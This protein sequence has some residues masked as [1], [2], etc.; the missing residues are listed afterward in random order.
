MKDG[1]DKRAKDYFDVER[2]PVDHL[3][4]HQNKVGSDSSPTTFDIPKTFYLS[5]GPQARDADVYS[6]WQGHRLR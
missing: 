3:S 6:Y 2:R 1:K 4:L 5:R